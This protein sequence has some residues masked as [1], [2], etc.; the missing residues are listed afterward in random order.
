MKKSILMGLV[1]GAITVTTLMTI[2][3]LS[4]ESAYAQL[5][6]DNGASFFAPNA[7]PDQAAGGWMPQEAPGQIVGPDNPGESSA[8]SAGQQGLEAG[9]IGP[10]LKCVPGEPSC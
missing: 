1:I 9:I 3:A 2:A 7:V 6:K 4:T 8:E 10:D 5:T